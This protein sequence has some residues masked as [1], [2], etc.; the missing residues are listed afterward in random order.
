M[1]K[2]KLGA[3]V[4]LKGPYPRVGSIRKIEGP[5]YLIC[6]RHSVSLIWH[7]EDDILLA[8]DDCP[9]TLIAP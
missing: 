5:L 4:A 8:W 9:D 2:F 3:G 1:A 6:M 7:M